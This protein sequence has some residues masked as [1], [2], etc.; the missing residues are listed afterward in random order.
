MTKM[1]QCLSHQASTSSDEHRAIIFADDSFS[2]STQPE[3]SIEFI[4]EVVLA[5]DL[6]KEPL[7][8]SR[9]CEKPRA[10]TENR[11]VSRCVALIAFLL[12]AVCFA[13]M[14]V[15]F[16]LTSK[17]DEMVRNSNSVLRKHNLPVNPQ[18]HVTNE[19]Y[20]N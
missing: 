17:I 19:S 7:R 5:D 6:P 11:K 12:L 2:S 9:K 10:E 20:F 4:S 8:Q 13:L 15:S 14:G 18:E 3:D 1:T 16:T